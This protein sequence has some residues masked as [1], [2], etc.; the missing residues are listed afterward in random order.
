MNEE[1]EAAMGKRING[2]GHPPLAERMIVVYMSES[3]S[4]TASR[5]E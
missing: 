3:L 2:E 5:R 1:V 4:T